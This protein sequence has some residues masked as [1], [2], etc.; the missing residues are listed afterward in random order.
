[1]KSNYFLNS[2]KPVV[3]N[4]SSIIWSMLGRCEGSDLSNFVIRVRAGRVILDGIWYSF[5]LMREY[6]SLRQEV[7]KGGLPTKSVYL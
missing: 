6:V 4:S 5:F 2:N 7:S 1:M 3:K